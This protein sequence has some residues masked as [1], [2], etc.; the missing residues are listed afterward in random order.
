MPT[1]KR[2][3]TWTIDDGYKMVYKSQEP[4]P[5]HAIDAGLQYSL[6]VILKMNNNDIDYLCGGTI[7][8]F[9]IGFHSAG[10]I[11]RGK[12][13]FFNLSPNRAA[14]YLIEPRLT[15]TDA[16]VRKFSPHRRQCYFNTER[17]LRFYHHYTRI[18]CMAECIS[19]YMVLKC[20]CVHF[21]M[22]RMLDFFHFQSTQL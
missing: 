6:L 17:K 16:N 7:Q 10:D 19:S 21:S 3:S 11:P 20:G 15:K 18:H 13:H 22:L 14:F 8:G 12:K 9:R 1:Q 4:Y 2:V 5:F